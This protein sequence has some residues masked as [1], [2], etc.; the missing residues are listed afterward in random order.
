LEVAVEKANKSSAR[1]LA[2]RPTFRTRS[3]NYDDQVSIEDRCHKRAFGEEH[4]PT[5]CARS[6]VAIQP[7]GR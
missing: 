2:R 5:I 6:I 1:W 3:T 4:R 7:G